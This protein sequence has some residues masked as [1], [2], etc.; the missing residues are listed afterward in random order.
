VG[1]LDGVEDD[2][3]RPRL[4]ALE[5]ELGK[6]RLGGGGGDAE[7]SAGVKSAEGVLG[8]EWAGGDVEE[9]G[10]DG[11]GVKGIGDA[12]VLI[13]MVE[14]WFMNFSSHEYE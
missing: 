12:D 14:R 6:L 4:A 13:G 2:E 9:C 10:G 11:E 3:V 7:G 8:T 5:E 1:K